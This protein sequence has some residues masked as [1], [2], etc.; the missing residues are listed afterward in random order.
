MILLLRADWRRRRL[1]VSPLAWRKKVHPFD[2]PDV[3]APAVALGWAVHRL[4]GAARPGGTFPAAASVPLAE[5]VAFAA[6]AYYLWLEGKRTVQFQRPKGIVTGQ[7]L[8]LAGVARLAA[9]FFPDASHPL[10]GGL[11]A[12]QLLSLLSIAAGTALLLRIVPAFLRGK[13]E[14]RILDHVAEWGDAVQPEYHPPTPECP[15]P[16]RWRMFDSM[17]AE[18]EVLDFLKRL[19]ITLKPQLVVETGSFMGVSTLRIAEGLREN[20]FGRIISVEY[21]PVVFARAKQRIEASGLREWIEL[22]NESSLEMQI[23][24]AID[25]FFSDSDIP[26]REKEVRRFLPQINP[27]GLIL[28]HDASSHYKIVR[29]GALRMEQEGLLSVVLLPCPRGLVMAQKREGRA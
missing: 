10:F 7:F 3:A 11:T 9:E 16:E 23:P 22:R 18:L 21:D 14:H 4:L 15:H 26:I 1:P 13:E 2:W 12:A 29:E 19:I 6:I 27:H 8:I 20:G 5:S 25:I 17:T 24:G 28:I